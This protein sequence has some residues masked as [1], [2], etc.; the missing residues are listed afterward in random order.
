MSHPQPPQ[1]QPSAIETERYA[2]TLHNAA[3]ATLVVC[4]ILAL[5]P[6]R[7]LDMYTIGLV[8]LTGYSANYLIRESSGRSIWQQITRP[9]RQPLPKESTPSA[10]VIGE[11][12]KEGRND[13][14][15][16]YYEQGSWKAQRQRE[17]KDDVEEGKS[18]S[19]MIVDQVWS[20]WNQ[21][22][23]NEEDEET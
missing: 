5:L 6:P 14:G 9:Q 2:K 19:D 21:G 20:V 8:G 3:I 22:K 15:S 4:P 10:S 16:A 18:F 23:K 17:I 7:K 11:L 12:Q 13:I 1:R